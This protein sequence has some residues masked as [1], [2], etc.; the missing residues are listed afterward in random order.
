M[1]FYLDY[2]NIPLGAME[3]HDNRWGSPYEESPLQA[4]ASVEHALHRTTSLTAHRHAAAEQIAWIVGFT[5]F[6]VAVDLQELFHLRTMVQR[7][8]RHNWWKGWFTHCKSHN[9][10]I[11]VL[12]QVQYPVL[13][14]KS[15]M[16]CGNFIT[17]VHL[18]SLCDY[19]RSNILLFACIYGIETFG[20]FSEQYIEDFF[21]I[22][23]LLGGTERGR[24][25]PYHPSFAQS[26]TSIP[27]A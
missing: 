7:P 4:D 14:G 2:V 16:V 22:L 6:L 20:P 18:Y 19:I 24:D 5:Q 1:Y 13:A 15:P 25:D 23:M 9:I 21:Y 8:I 11:C 17:R 3:I 27:A 12:L 10:I 26:V